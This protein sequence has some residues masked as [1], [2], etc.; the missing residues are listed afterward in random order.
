MKAFHQAASV[1]SQCF[2]RILNLAAVIQPAYLFNGFLA[3]V[4][5]FQILNQII[6]MTASLPAVCSQCSSIPLRFISLTGLAALWK[7]PNIQLLMCQHNAAL[8]KSGIWPPQSDSS[9]KSA[10]ACIIISPAAIPSR[11]RKSWTKASSTLPC[12]RRNPIQQ[13][14]ILWHSPMPIC[15][16]LS[17]QRI[18]LWQ[19]KTPFMPMI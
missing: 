5:I 15:G 13:N 4:R 12:W 17:C 3:T 7:K 8:Y 14:I 19:K 16:D 6:R 2:D 11:L 10:P 1:L 18:V 9:R